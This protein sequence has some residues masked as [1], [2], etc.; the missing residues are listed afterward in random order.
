MNMKKSLL[1]GFASLL[2]IGVS[3]QS[4]I[5]VFN[6][7]AAA[8]PAVAPNATIYMHVAA[9]SNIKVTL[10][11]KNTSTSTKMYNV[12]RYDV[13]LNATAT[14]T[15]AAYFCFAGNCYAQSTMVSPSALTLTAGQKASE[16]PGSFQNL[17]SDL[18][19]ADVEG[20]SIVKY[21]FINVSLASDSVQVVIQYNGS[22]P[23][24][25]KT[26]GANTV[27]K[28][29]VYPNPCTNGVVNV[30]TSAS[31]C[32]VQI[33]DLVGKQVKVAPVNSL[34][35]ITSVNVNDLP[36]GTYFVRVVSGTSV[37][38]EKLILTNK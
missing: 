13:K 22:V 16:V 8:S 21:T 25:I 4:S 5:S 27:S 33:I 10:D 15:A 23:T 7:T 24:G 17:V 32:Q 28:I 14:A 2:T 35:K 38:T 12:K 20:L 34:A 18:D 3:A 30:E 36:N 1:I 37:T 26:V 11:I 31:A 9:E 19:E 6:G 29:N